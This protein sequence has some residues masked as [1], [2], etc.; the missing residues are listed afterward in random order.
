MPRKTMTEVE[1]VVAET[2]RL[3]DNNNIDAAILVLVTNDGERIIRWGADTL[4]GALSCVEGAAI[5]M[6]RM[7]HFVV[8]AGTKKSGAH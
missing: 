4:Q 6:Q 3:L 7:T 8:D 5:Q 2:Q 1:R